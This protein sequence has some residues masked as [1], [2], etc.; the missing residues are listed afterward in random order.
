VARL[1]I[2][3]GADPT[4]IGDYGTTCLMAASRGGHLEVVRLLRARPSFMDTVNKR[5]SDGATALWWA[6]YMG[7][8]AVARFLLEN[9]ADRT[10]ADDIGF[11]PMAMAKQHSSDPEVS[12]EG[13]RECLD[14]LMV[15]V[16]STKPPPLRFAPIERSLTREVFF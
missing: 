7:R 12:M 9:G 11:T 1:L 2:Q 6:C 8:G 14:A 4:I 16:S 10:I 5:F 3:K 13:R 15:S